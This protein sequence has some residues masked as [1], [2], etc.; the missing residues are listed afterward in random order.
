[1]DLIEIAFKDNC[2]TLV[3][4]ESTMTRTQIY[5]VMED[6]E[7]SPEISVIRISIMAGVSGPASWSLNLTLLRGPRESAAYTVSGRLALSQP[8]EIIC[9][10]PSR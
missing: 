7:K 4:L 1:M 6:F 2:I 9:L 8:L 10:I 5:R 3:R